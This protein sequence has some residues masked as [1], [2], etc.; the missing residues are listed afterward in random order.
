MRISGDVAN[1]DLML[2]TVDDL[3]LAAT[4]SRAGNE[5]V[6][7]RNVNKGY[8]IQLG[9]D[10][11]FH[12][13]TCQLL[14]LARLETRVGLANYVDTTLPTNNLAVRMTVLERLE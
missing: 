9:M 1:H 11:C 2:N 8:R 12:G 3:G 4:H 13:Y 6:P 7:G 10:F 5:F 14:A